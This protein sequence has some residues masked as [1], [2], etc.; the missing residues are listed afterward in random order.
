MEIRIN[1]NTGLL[2]VILFCTISNYDV[3]SQNL[4]LSDRITNIIEDLA[5]EATDEQEAAR[6]TEMLRELADDPVNINSSDPDEI[7][8]LF[9]LTDFQVKSLADYTRTTG[10]IL[11]VYEIAAVP[12]F[13]R[14]MAATIS[15]FIRLVNYRALSSYYGRWRNDIISSTSF[16]TT[17]RDSSLP[18]SP[19]R[20]LS[21]YRFTAGSLSGGFTI[22][23]DAGEKFFNGNSV[24]P[25]FFSANICYT[26]NGIIRKVIAGDFSARSGQ[27]TNINTGIRTGLSL[28]SPG[29]M[30]VKSEIRPYTSTD[31]NNFFRGAAVSAR[32]KN[33]AAFI[34]FSCNNR[35]ATVELSEGTEGDHITGF[36]NTGLHTTKSA[37]EKKD[38][39]V[40]TTYGTEISYDFK[41]IKIGFSGI[42]DRL[43]MRMENSA[44]RPESLYNFTGS[45][46]SVL[47][48]FYNS[49][50]KK[51]LLFGEISA[52]DRWR[53]AIV[54][55]LSL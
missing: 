4:S 26:G 8:R 3:C 44:I 6:F 32:F 9:F 18:G 54:Q 21:K 31:E 51:I 20:L 22:E 14:D 47:T 13:D 55:G 38:A 46:N 30:A 12:G 37:I 5:S 24:F 35:D 52:N 28:V 34:F 48:A 40:I 16:R 33:L 15:P 45:A 11:S 25:D 10:R 42:S 43:S 17:D 53:Y 41:K 50:I 27:G 36:Y 2:C 39:V 29:Y 49:A 7:S 19:C 1:I 23:K